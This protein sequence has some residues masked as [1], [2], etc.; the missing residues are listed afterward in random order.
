MSENESAV[1]NRGLMW[2][3][4]V[5]GGVDLLAL[6]AVVMP[7]E[8]MSYVNDLC[9]LGPF[10]ESRIVGYLARTTSLLYALHGAMILFISSDIERYRPLITFLGAAAL[11]HGGILL[12]IDWSAEMPL[13]W[14]LTEGPGFAITGIVVLWLQARNRSAA[15]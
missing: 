6:A 5:M 3:L 2:G 4:R 9:G 14:T 11:I 7:L 15:A 13:F 12:A 8:W 1:A 10:P